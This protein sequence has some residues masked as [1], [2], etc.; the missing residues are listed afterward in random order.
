MLMPSIW[1]ESLF[2][3]FFGADYPA[4]D[5]LKVNTGEIMKTD[6]KESETGYQL[7]ISLPGYKKDDINAEIKNGY[8]TI[9]ASIT[10]NKDEKDAKTGK[11]IRRERY[12]GSCSRSFYVGK[13]V[14]E[15]D[16]KAKYEDGVLKLTVPKKEAK[17]VVEQKKY[18]A[19]EG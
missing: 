10:Q 11:Y 15:E 8:L 2:D 3:N 16:I 7:D 4:R 19:I 13:D 5:L 1:G 14:T 9:N 17:P 6:I 18:I 12:S